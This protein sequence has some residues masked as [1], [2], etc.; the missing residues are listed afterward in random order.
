MIREK[1]SIEWLLFY[2]SS[3]WSKIK[4][5]LFYEIPIGEQLRPTIEYW[6]LNKWCST[7]L[8]YAVL[9]IVSHVLLERNLEKN[10]RKEQQM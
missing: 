10:V 1:T 4:E 2:F 7:I 5:F 8:S 3:N 9:F 6:A